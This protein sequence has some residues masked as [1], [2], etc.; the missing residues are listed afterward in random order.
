MSTEQATLIDEPVRARTGPEPVALRSQHD[1]SLVTD[2]LEH[3][4]E[5]LEKLAKKNEEEGYSREARAIKADLAAIEHHILPVFRDQR[6]MPLV[7]HEQLAKEIAAALRPHIY[8]AFDGLGDPKVHVTFDG[9]QRRRD[10]LLDALA[11]RI[12]HFATGLA[13]EAFNEGHAAREQSAPA[14]ARRQIGELRAQDV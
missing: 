1:Y 12:T 10:T 9:I 5:D 14:L 4:K 2:A 7:T 13:D 11:L 6:E 8:R 3:R